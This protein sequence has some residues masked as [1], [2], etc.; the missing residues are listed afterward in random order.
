MIVGNVTTEWLTPTIKNP[1]TDSIIILSE[2]GQ[3]NESYWYYIT[4]CEMMPVT[5]RNYAIFFATLKLMKVVLI[6]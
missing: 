3:K 5:W 1:S 2:L 6:Y 4:I